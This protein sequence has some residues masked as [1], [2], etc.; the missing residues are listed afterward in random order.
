MPLGGHSREVRGFSSQR[1]SSSPRSPTSYRVNPAARSDEDGRQGNEDGRRGNKGSIPLQSTQT[2]ERSQFGCFLF[3]V[4]HTAPP[5]PT[6][7]CSSTPTLCLYL[8]HPI[9]N[10]I[11]CWPIGSALLQ[12]F[13]SDRN[14]NTIKISIKHCASNPASLHLPQTHIIKKTS[15][16][17]RPDAPI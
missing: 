14:L 11:P 6:D 3:V 4:L 1:P 13:P 17:I 9:L 10:H 5:K 15:G 8:L 16:R 12:L 2:S 7:P